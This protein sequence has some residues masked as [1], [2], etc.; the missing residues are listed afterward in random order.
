MSSFSLVI[1]F[2]CACVCVRVRVCVFQSLLVIE[3]LYDEKKH[4]YSLSLSSN[5]FS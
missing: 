4:Q 3:K 5:S 1:V 2:V